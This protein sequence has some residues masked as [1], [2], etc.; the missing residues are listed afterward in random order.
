[1]ARPI[2]PTPILYGEDAVR[3]EER[4][5]NANG[6]M[7]LVL[8]SLFLTGCSVA[9]YNNYIASP[10]PVDKLQKDVNEAQ[11]FLYNYQ[12]DLDWYIS[13]DSLNAEF[14]ALRNTI[15]APMTSKEFFDK[16]VP[17][18]YSVRQGHDRL[19]QAL[20]KYTHRQNTALKKVKEPM[21]QFTY[22]IDNNRLFILKNQS[23]DSSIKT[24]TEIIAVNGESTPEIVQKSYALFTSDGYN[25]TFYPRYAAKNFSKIYRTIHPEW[26]DSVCLLL[27]YGK[28]NREVYVKPLKLSNKKSKVRKD[29]KAIKSGY[30]SSTGEYSHTLT[31]LTGDSSIAL[32]KISSFVFNNPF[33]LSSFY[34]KCFTALFAAKTKTLII[35][36]RNNPGGEIL[37][38]RSLYAYLADSAFIFTDKGKV[39]SPFSCAF[40]GKSLS[41]LISRKSVL[42]KTIATIVYPLYYGITSIIALSSV[43]KKQDGNYYYSIFSSKL[44]QPEKK[45]F[46]GKV[47]VLANGG[48][49]SASCLLLSNL[50]GSKRAFVVGEETGGAYNGTVAGQMVTKTLSASKL[51]LTIGLLSLRPYYQTNSEGRGIFPDKEIVPDMEHQINRQDTE[52]EWVMSQK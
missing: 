40:H 13:T 8:M 11:K 6:F 14:D 47:Y 43:S 37:E 39:T 32:L 7:T 18:I 45:R 19:R 42:F 46:A 4:M 28:I 49:F 24:G 52:L 34:E 22:T 29:V 51:K 15:A 25:T 20:P 10:L 12:P 17:V 44:K 5:K 48:C 1:M 21:A 50:Q 30:D 41:T 33:E 9:R 36:L 23:A 35:D 26:M 2:K 16:L 3:F 38:V 31:F 27:Q